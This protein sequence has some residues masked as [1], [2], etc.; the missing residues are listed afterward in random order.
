[1]SLQNFLTITKY[2]GVDPEVAYS[3]TNKH[4]INSKG[5][6]I[7]GII[8]TILQGILSQVMKWIPFGCL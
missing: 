4:G 8:M 7:N 2:Q 1:M 6:V 5:L 3:Y